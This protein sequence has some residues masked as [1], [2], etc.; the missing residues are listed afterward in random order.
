[1]KFLQ[2]RHE[3]DSAHLKPIERVLFLQT[4]KHLAQIDLEEMWQKKCLGYLLKFSKDL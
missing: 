4:F 2:R 3:V 1:M